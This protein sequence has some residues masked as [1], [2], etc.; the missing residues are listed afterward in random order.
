M[1][2]D[3]CSKLWATRALMPIREIDLIDGIFTLTYVRN[4]GVAFGLLQGTGM[5]IAMITIIV[6]GWAIWWAFQRPRLARI[7]IWALGL[8]TGGSLG[9]LI[10]RIRLGY[11]VD[12]FDFQVWPVFNVADICICTAAALWMYQIWQQER[13]ASKPVKVKSKR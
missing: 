11:V 9:N 7:E 6:I 12:F 8:V 2:L 4:R 10:D 5:A 13:Q 1:I 3:Q